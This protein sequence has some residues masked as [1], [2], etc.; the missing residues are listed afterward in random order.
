MVIPRLLPAL[1]AGL[2]EN[3]GPL[4]SHVLVINGSSV[5]LRLNSDYYDLQSKQ[6]Q[7]AVEVAEM[8]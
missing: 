2:M 5:E 1:R 4:L 6:H 3:G 7:P 8:A